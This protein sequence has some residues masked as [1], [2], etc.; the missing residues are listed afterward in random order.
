MPVDFISIGIAVVIALVIF[1]LAYFF[2]IKDDT[3][4]AN[5]STIQ[6]SINTLNAQLS[7]QNTT[8][9]GLNKTITDV[10]ATIK[11]SIENLAATV[12][13]NNTDSLK[14][15][16]DLKT[17]NENLTKSTTGSAKTLQDNINTLQT[18]LNDFIIESNRTDEKQNTQIATLTKKLSEL[19]ERESK[20][21]SALIKKLGELDTRES[22]ETTKLKKLIDDVIAQDQSNLETVEKRFP[23]LKATIDEIKAES[24]KKIKALQ[25]DLDKNTDNDK[26]YSDY[27]DTIK[28]YVSNALSLPDMSDKVKKM[29]FGNKDMVLEMYTLDPTSAV[30]Y[31]FDQYYGVMGCP[32]PKERIKDDRN[33]IISLQHAATIECIKKI[34]NGIDVEKCHDYIFLLFATM[35]RTGDGG[36]MART[37]GVI[38][39]DMNS[40]KL[41][42]SKKAEVQ[43][44]KEFNKW[45]PK[46][47]F[48]PIEKDADGV[49]SYPYSEARSASKKLVEMLLLKDCS[50]LFPEEGCE[51]FNKA[52]S[53]VSICYIPPPVVATATAPQPVQQ[54]ATAATISNQQN[55]NAIVKPNIDLVDISGDWIIIN[56]GNQGLAKITAGENKTTWN[57]ALTPLPGNNLPFMNLIKYVASR[58][59]SWNNKLNAIF[60]D[61]T[62]TKLVANYP[63]TNYSFERVQAFIA[64][65]K[66][67]P[68]ISN[69]LLAQE[70]NKILIA[71]R[72]QK[73]MADSQV[74]TRV[75]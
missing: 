29:I 43:L 22:E 11:T 37:E 52:I 3:I 61:S 60:T 2:G 50:G 39:L 31:V 64:N 32:F 24:D 13:T 1:A 21:T 17:A 70:A 65:E 25:A 8:I 40:M 12:K 41:V 47:N 54:V 27:V 36:P 34:K 73:I 53:K 9:T 30:E 58:G 48:K 35:L 10:Q 45:L 75:V 66:A 18:K 5:I 63:T 72:V 55:L 46:L 74:A 71:E 51:N 7:G 16:N 14:L 28:N 42:V 6:N 44:E 33:P 57:L 26:K 67:K 69:A 68:N 4:V 49:L 15:I 23:E 38:N 62:Y 20:E 19:D 59:Y 56:D